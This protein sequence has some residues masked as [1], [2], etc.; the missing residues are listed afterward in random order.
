MLGIVSIRVIAGSG[1]VFSGK[2]RSVLYLLQYTVIIYT[3][4]SK[5]IF[6]IGFDVLLFPLGDMTIGPL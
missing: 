3:R 5:T 2:R 6:P 1:L 4:H